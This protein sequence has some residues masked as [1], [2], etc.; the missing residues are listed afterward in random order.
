MISKER[1]RSAAP[2]YKKLQMLRS[3]TNSHARS[4]T[5][6]IVDATKYIEELKQRVERMNQD[7]A[8]MAQN[9]STCHNT[10]IPVKVRVEAL[11][12]GY[13][14]KVFSERSC[15]GLLVFILE[16][17]EELGL[18]VLQARV[19]CSECFLLEA[20]GVVKDDDEGSVSV[21]SQEIKRAVS[22]AIQNWSGEGEVTNE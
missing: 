4:K 22:Q 11:D 17:F 5:S 16:A 6:I 20:V 7:L 2:S 8:I 10:L 19:S 12:K 15:R 13:L 1:K 14:I 21:D 3:I 9:S 18:E